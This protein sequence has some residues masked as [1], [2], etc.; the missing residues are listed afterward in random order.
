VHRR[1]TDRDATTSQPIPQFVQCLVGRLRNQLAH[2]LLMGRQ[3]ERPVTTDLAGLETAG[4][5]PLLDQLDRR[6]LTDCKAIRGSSA[7]RPALNCRHDPPANIQRKRCCH[8][9]LASTAQPSA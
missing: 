9:E 5:F 1:A 3:S 4:L 6:T 8:I 2:Q 7:R